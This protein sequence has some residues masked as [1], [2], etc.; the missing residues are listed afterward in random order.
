MT[1]RKKVQRKINSYVR[2]MNKNIADDE[3]WRGR[4]VVRQVGS[5]QWTEFDDHSG[6]QLFVRLRMTDTKTGYT[7]DWRADNYD[8]C[9]FHGYKLWEVVNQF[10]CDCTEGEL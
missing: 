1:K 8:I 6:G 9:M 5:P 4:F 7:R 2:A 3:K 10:V